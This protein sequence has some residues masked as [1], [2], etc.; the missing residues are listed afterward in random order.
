MSVTPIRD[1]QDVLEPGAEESEEVLPSA[2]SNAPDIVFDTTQS[3]TLA[4]VR[5]Y[6]PPRARVN[7]LLSVYFNAK[8]T[9]IPII[10]NG[11]FVREYE[12]FW[13][14]PSPISFLWISMLFSMLYI[15]SQIDEVSGRVSADYPSDPIRPRFLTIAGQALV[16]GKYHTA[17]PHSVE[18]VLLYA[19]CK[20]VRKE[21]P[22]L[23]AWMTVGISARL[24]MRLGYHRDPNHL[25]NI[26]P[27]EG[28]MRRRTFFFIQTFDL[29]LSFQAGLPTIVHEEDCDVEPPS[30]LFDTDFD[31]DYTSLPPSRP[32][33]DQTPMLYYIVKG[34]LMKI[35]RRVIR[36]A[37]SLKPP[38]YE[39]TMN[40][41]NE[42]HQFH[43]DVPSILQ[44]KP[45][46]SSFTDEPYIILNR[47]NIDIMY[48]KSLCVLHRR[49]LSHDR[50]DPKLDYSRKTCSDAALQILDYQ[51]QLHIA[52]QPE[53]QLHNDRWMLASLTTADFLLA[54]MI[55]CL[56][57]YLSHSRP[58]ITSQQD[59]KAQ[60]TKY[61]ALRFSH[62][63]WASRRASSRDARRAL[64]ALAVMLSRV[65]R[66][67]LPSTPISITSGPFDESQ[68]SSDGGRA[69]GTAEGSWGST[70]WNLAET[71]ILGQDFN[72]EEY[73]HFDF[74][75]ADPLNAIFSNSD[76]I[77]W[78]LVDQALLEQ[79]NDGNSAV[80]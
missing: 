23:D 12:S 9:Q 40:L 35:F 26:P 16:T 38:A 77:D 79:S 21:D 80:D 50:S 52:C 11:K 28:E 5:K 33:T 14:D 64:N 7:K 48:Q 74:Y 58:T 20:Y 29:L 18:A 49:Y 4:D 72:M 68:A 45:L 22:D 62:D 24:A 31:E 47:L 6:L 46:S 44:V 60:V 65:P 63:I 15:A 59:W 17:R 43:M 3:L 78:G 69:T 39:V 53:G 67:T 66:P 71:N 61:D 70:S 55:A 36:H 27:F 34:R 51:G 75:S 57:L 41:D 19:Y 37:L 73:T 13:I 32:S 76:C 54:A 2:T 10:H 1:I 25:A 42:L 8:Y 56:D 30:N